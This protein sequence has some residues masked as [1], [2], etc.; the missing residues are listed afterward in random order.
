MPICLHL[1]FELRDEIINELINYPYICQAMK[2]I[3]LIPI[4]LLQCLMFKNRRR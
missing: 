2:K 1:D 3:Q 4:V